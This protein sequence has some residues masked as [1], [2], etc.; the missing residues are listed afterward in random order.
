MKE[1]GEQDEVGDASGADHLHPRGPGRDR[2]DGQS[3]TLAVT[4]QILGM[5]MAN[6]F[7]PTL[8]GMAAALKTGGIAA[9]RWPGGSA[10]DTFHWQTNHE[11]NGGWA[12]PK[13]TFDKF[14]AGLVTPNAC[15]S[16]DA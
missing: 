5:N 14:F 4:D 9:L 13:A 16:D 15:R 3:P 6:W 8:A 7:D 10:S 12:D 1:Q 11:C 2:G